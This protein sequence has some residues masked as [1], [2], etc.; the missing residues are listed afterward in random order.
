MDERRVVGMRPW[1]FSRFAWWAPVRA[2]RLAALRIGLALVMLLDVLWT[3]LPNLHDYFGPGGI[4]SREL[5][6]WWLKPGVWRWSLLNTGGEFS[7]ARW[8]DASNAWLLDAAV[9]VWIAALVGMLLGLETRICVLTVWLL[10]VSF[11]NL[12]P[13]IDN[14]GD[15]VRTITLLYLVL[16]PCGAAW[17][18]DRRFGRQPPG[19]VYVDPWALRLLFVQMTLIYFCNGCYKLAGEQWR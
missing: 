16:T 3:Y 19:P 6:E 1:P 18:L 2:E 9:Y 12:N 7:P 10:S 15:L 13:S 14:S 5:H 17:S 11:A 4:G 8:L